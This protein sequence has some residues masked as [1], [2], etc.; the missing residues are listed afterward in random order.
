MGRVM[1]AMPPADA[2]A[3]EE[4]APAAEQITNTYA[5]GCVVIVVDK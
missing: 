2:T 1:A 5:C 4:A 3:T